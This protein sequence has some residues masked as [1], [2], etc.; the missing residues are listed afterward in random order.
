[1]YKGFIFQCMQGMVHFFT[2]KAEYTPYTAIYSNLSG[3]RNLFVK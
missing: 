3:L 1:M 2:R